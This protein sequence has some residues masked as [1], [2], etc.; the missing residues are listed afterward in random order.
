MFL[1]TETSRGMKIIGKRHTMSFAEN[2]TG[3]LFGSFMPRRNEIQNRTNTD[4]L[5]V[6]IYPSGF[7]KSFN[8]TRPFEKW[9]AAEVNSSESIPV[10]METMIIPSGLYAVFLFKG[11][12]AN[13]GPFFQNIY[14]N[15][16]PASGYVV[17][18]RPH[19]DVLGSKYKHNDP[20]SEEEIW[21]PIR[22]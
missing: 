11:T 10:E 2:T 20:E 15:W 13:A 12:M 1:R 9:A 7:F 22:S 3:Q 14:A 17:D 5:C 8:P 18:D 19:F 21:I 16:F 4:I 6:S